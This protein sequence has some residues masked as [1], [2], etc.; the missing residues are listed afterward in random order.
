MEHETN[1]KLDNAATKDQRGNDHES[2]AAILTQLATSAPD[3]P[4]HMHLLARG[5]DLDTRR[6]LRSLVGTFD[7]VNWQGQVETEAEPEP[8]TLPAVFQEQKS[9]QATTTDWLIHEP[10]GEYHAKR[11]R[12]LSS[13][14]LAD[15]RHCPL[16]HRKK[17]GGLIGDRD[18]AAYAL[19]RAGHVL[20]LEGRQAYEEEYSVGGP[21]NPKTAKPYG[22]DTK[23]FAEWAAEQG[24]QV[25]SE[26]DA[27]IVEA[28]NASVH[29]HH[30][31]ADLLS[32]GVPEG[33]ARAV[34]CGI[35]CQIRLDWYD[36]RN[37]IVDLKTCENLSWFEHDA[38]RYGYIHQLAFYRAVTLMVIDTTVPVYVIAVEKREPFRCGVWLVGEEVLGIAETENDEAMRRLAESRRHDVWPTGYEE[39]RTLDQI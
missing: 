23:K 14:Q 9:D 20:I 17:I 13:H 29:D 19:G 38:R 37:G 10:A 3:D 28:M 8:E 35:E 12:Y 6:W 26:G 7:T 34:Y 2:Q 5:C 27:G 1:D 31:A 21:I 30:I 32:V 33:V 39:L 4:V 36:P 11:T 15:F 25:I 22:K 24:G 18:S 16:L